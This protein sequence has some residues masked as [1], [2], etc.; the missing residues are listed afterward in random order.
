VYPDSIASALSAERL[1]RFFVKVDNHHYQVSKELR[2]SIVFA[3]QNLISDAPFSKLDL[4]SCRNVLIYLEPEVQE[5][6]ISLLH[7]ALNDDGFL[8]LGPSESIGRASGM[9]EPVV[10]KWRLYWRIG[11][12]RRDL[13]SIPIAA[14]D[15]RRPAT[16][17][18]APA[19]RAPD[20]R[21]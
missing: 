9:F 7:F 20:S 12:V 1:K 18:Q 11:P 19:V 10:K 3:P 14:M 8:F 13:V 17:P 15:E 6:I 2:D 16:A 21:N 5:K 4:I